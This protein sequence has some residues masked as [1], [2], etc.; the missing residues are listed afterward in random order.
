MDGWFYGK[1]HYIKLVIWAYPN[2]WKPP[3][4]NS[5]RN[6]DFNEQKVGLNQKRMDIIY[7]FY[8][9]SWG[10]KCKPWDIQ[11]P[12][13]QEL[14][15]DQRVFH[16][17]V[18]RWNGDGW[19]SM[20]IAAAR[21][22]NVAARFLVASNETHMNIPYV[23]C[24]IYI[25]IYIIYNMYIHICISAFHQ[26]HPK[27]LVNIGY[28]EFLDIFKICRVQRDQWPSFSCLNPFGP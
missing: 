28:M 19:R 11:V 1:S 10:F 18:D 15:L 2:L 9:A 3:N 6:A 27:M 14:G 24:M 26:N 20:V 23:S 16:R 5:S 22:R 7:Q 21:S 4:S 13:R 17:Y 8:Q 12:K 25:Y